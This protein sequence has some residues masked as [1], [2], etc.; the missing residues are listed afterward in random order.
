MR[1]N[2]TITLSVLQLLLLR[3]ALCV[4]YFDDRDNIYE[5]EEIQTVS[6]MHIQNNLGMLYDYVWLG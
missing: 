4:I 3:N 1:I 2:I 6:T 5:S